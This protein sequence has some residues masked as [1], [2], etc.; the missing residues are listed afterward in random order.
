MIRRGLFALVAAAALLLPPCFMRAQG[1]A[2]CAMPLPQ[3]DYWISSGFGM[4][5]HPL[6][7]IRRMHLGVDLACRR[8]TPVHA[9]AD[10]RVMFASRWG[11]YGR[12][13]V[14]IHLGHVMT[15][16]AHL[17][18]FSPGLRPGVLVRRGEVI[19]FSGASGCVTGPHLHF[20][21]WEAGQRVN[22]E[23][24]CVSLRSMRAP[25]VTVK[26]GN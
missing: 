14:L 15:L 18:H 3:G 11:C 23:L 22:P 24:V 2:G 25:L 1:A 21:V 5:L 10:G 8:G 12:V 9:A 7:G 17:S 26:G 13:L 20:E 19:A 4:R 6:Y 16:Y